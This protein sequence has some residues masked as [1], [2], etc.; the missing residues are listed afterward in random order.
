[1][2]IKTDSTRIA[3]I[4]IKAAC[5]SLIGDCIKEAIALSAIQE[6]DIVL[7]H[8]ENKYIVEYSKISDVI[9]DLD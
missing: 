9:R 8:N 4:V 1:M 3:Q 6:T 7:I 5:G 2:K